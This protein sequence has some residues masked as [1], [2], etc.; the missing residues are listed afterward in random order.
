MNLLSRIHA[1]YVRA[2]GA[3]LLPALGAAMVLGVL[4]AHFVFGWRA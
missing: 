1:S 4:I 2:P 3:W